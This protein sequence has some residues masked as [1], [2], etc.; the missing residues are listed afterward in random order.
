MGP[1]GNRVKFGGEGWVDQFLS[2]GLSLLLGQEPFKN[3][4]VV[5]GWVVVVKRHIRVLLWVKA[6]GFGL[7]PS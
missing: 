1:L 7:G 5:G 4:T 6:F 3:L 2:L